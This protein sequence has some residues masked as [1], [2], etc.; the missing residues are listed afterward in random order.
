M[1]TRITPTHSDYDDIHEAW[2]ENGRP[3]QF[4]R[5]GAWGGAVYRCLS[6]NQDNPDF[7]VAYTDGPTELNDKGQVTKK[8]WHTV[9]RRYMY[10]KADIDNK[11]RV[12]VTPPEFP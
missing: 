9:N 3:S 6:P 2:V 7:Y 5:E 11:G 10:M 8:G 4:D 1:S 12:S